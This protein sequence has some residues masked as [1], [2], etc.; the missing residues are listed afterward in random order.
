ML[1][2]LVRTGSFES[3]VI[4]D[5]S[6]KHYCENT[7]RIILNAVY[8]SI[9]FRLHSTINPVPGLWEETRTPREKPMQ[10]SQNVDLN[11]GLSYCEATALTTI[12]TI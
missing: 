4:L 12:P 9:F 3:L 2:V 11:P 6:D 5:I 1:Y 8:P 10:T 7:Q